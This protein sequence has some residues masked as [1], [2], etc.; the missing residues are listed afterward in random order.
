[1]KG[2]GH[3]NGASLAMNESALDSILQLGNTI[4]SSIRASFKQCPQLSAERLSYLIPY[5][6]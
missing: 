2:E 4:N 5:S 6:D 3:F 1:M